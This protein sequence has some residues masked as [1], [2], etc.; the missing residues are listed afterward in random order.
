MVAVRF[1]IGRRLAIA[2]AAQ[3]S[4][5]AKEQEKHSAANNKAFKT[6]AAC[7]RSARQA[8]EGG[9]QKAKVCELCRTFRPIDKTEKQCY[10]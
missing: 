3:A 6:F 1:L 5:Q 4:N 9:H 8:C 2:A 10:M 7:P